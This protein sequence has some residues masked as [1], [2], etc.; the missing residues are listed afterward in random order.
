MAN[1]NTW[2]SSEC[3]PSISFWLWENKGKRT[4]PGIPGQEEGINAG[5]ASGSDTVAPSVTPQCG[6]KHSLFQ[7]SPTGRFTVQ[8]WLLRWLNINKLTE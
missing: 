8:F 1:N 4:P 6:I 3:P 2:K 5:P 7:Y